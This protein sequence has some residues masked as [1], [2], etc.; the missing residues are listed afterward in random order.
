M[1]EPTARPTRILTPSLAL[2]ASLLAMPAIAAKTDVIVL[3]NGDRITGEVK[4]L[5]YGQLKFKTDH[6]GTVYIEWDKIASVSMWSVLNLS[7][8]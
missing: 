3:V 2:A 6:M 4:N 1:Q 5:S 7:W 8:P